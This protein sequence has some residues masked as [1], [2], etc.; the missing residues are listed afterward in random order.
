MARLPE[1]HVDLTV[2]NHSELVLLAK[3]CG[4]PA[5][6]GMSREVLIESLETFQPSELPIPF[7]EKRQLMSEWLK[8]WWSNIR[9]QMPKKVCPN[10]RLCRDLQVLDCY[11]ENEKQIKPGPARR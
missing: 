3:W 1:I 7:D 2:L 5:S 10:C 9:M 8:R 11:S 6:R 4:L